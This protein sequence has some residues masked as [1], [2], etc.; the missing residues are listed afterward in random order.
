MKYP[1][2]EALYSEQL[3]IVLLVVWSNLF[4]WFQPIKRMKPIKPTELI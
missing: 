2:L 4:N 1:D 3:N